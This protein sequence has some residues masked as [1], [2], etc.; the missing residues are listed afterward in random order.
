[1]TTG[2]SAVSVREIQYHAYGDSITYGLTLNDPAAEAYPTLVGADEKVGVL[3]YA[4]SGA[5]VCDIPARQIFANAD[6]PTLARH[7]TYSV[8]IG[9]NDVDNK[10]IGAY[11]SVFILCHEAI[12][13]WLAVPVEYKVLVQGDGVTTTGSG[14]IDTSDHWSAWTTAGQGS[15]I[16]FPIATTESGP[17]YLWPRINDDDPATYTYSLDGI[18]LGTASTQTTPR[19]ATSKGTTN[20]LGFIRLAPVPAG[21]HVVTF[22]QVSAGTNGVSVVGIGTPEVSTS[23]NLPT[24]LVGTIPYQL[25]SG[26]CNSSSDQPCLEY[27]LDIEADVNLFAADGLDVRLFD[28]RKYLRGTAAEMNDSLHPNVTGQIELSHAVE[29]SW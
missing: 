7:F 13:S 22:T 14:A 25:D 27:T 18:V 21:H 29:A 4:I 17:L 16:S 24:V 20:S 23:S 1:M 19:I 10:G 9:T 15:T 5:Q 26:K 11:E 6:S 28:T 12:L 8:L 2:C 3:N